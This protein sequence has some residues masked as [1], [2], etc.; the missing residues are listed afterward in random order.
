M[1]LFQ[2]KLTRAEWETI[3]KPVSD[4][5]K[6]ILNLIV[7]GYEDNNIKHNDTYT[8]LS[9]TK[10][11]KTPEIDWYIYDKYFQDD[12][13]R[14]INKYGKGTPISSISN[15]KF[16]SGR[17]LKPLKTSDS[18][19]IQNTDNV[20]RENK[21]KIF[22]F[23][24]VDLFEHMM[25]NIYK[26]NEDNIAYYLHTLIQLKKNSINN[27]NKF[28]DKYI[29][30]SIKYTRTIV[31]INDIVYNSYKLIECNKYLIKYADKELYPHQ[32][33]LF[34]LYKTQYDKTIMAEDNNKKE[35]EE[36]IKEK[37]IIERKNVRWMPKQHYLGDDEEEEARLKLEYE[38]NIKEQYELTTEQLESIENIN[39]KLD[40]LYSK[41]FIKKPTL[42]LYTAPTGTGKTLSPIGLSGQYKIIF[43]CVARHIGM[44]LAKSAISVNKKVAFAFGCE[45]S[46]DIRLHY[47]AAIDYTVNKKTGGIGKVDHSN[48][49]NVEIM[50]C[51]V[52]SY[53]TAMYYMLS[54]NNQDNIITYWDEP[55]ITL[56]YDNHD[57]HDV[58]HNNWKENK[59]PSVILSCATLP[60]NNEL[61]P[62]FSDFQ[63]KFPGAIVRNISSYDCKKSIPILDKDGYC[64][65]PHYLYNSYN[66]VSLCANNCN[67]NKSLLRYFDLR[68][69]VLFIKY[70]NEQNKNYL[71]LKDYFEDISDITMNSIK[72][73]Y[74][75]LLMEISE[76]D[77]DDI[78][79]YMIAKRKRRIGDNNDS[80]IRTYSEQTVNKQQG[81]PISRTQSVFSST[82]VAEKKINR[83]TGGLLA[84]TSDAHTLTDGPSIFL[85][86]DIDKIG[87]FYIQQ[88]KIDKSVFERIMTK[89]EYNENIIKKIDKMEA[90]ISAE[91]QKK[92]NSSDD[93]KSSKNSG[94][95]SNES[96]KLVE[97]VNTLRKKLKQISLDSMYLPNTK[98]HQEIWTP[99]GEIVN[100]AFVAD[101][102]E[103]NTS[104]I[105]QLNIE[106]NEKVLLLL[107]IGT[108]NLHN[109]NRYMEIMK[110]L[111]EEQRLYMIIASTDYIYG[112]NYQFCHGF[113]SKDLS[114]ISQQK[115]LQALGRIGRNNIQKDYTVRFRDNDMIKKLLSKPDK[116]IEATNMQKLFNSD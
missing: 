115:T 94:K 7:D 64:V 75:E 76:K 100:N 23:I 1:E 114:N 84:T 21:N 77:W 3:E 33:K 91:E 43:V 37:Q 8:F 78:Y 55:T 68:E 16:L 57:L 67:N 56:D 10:V 36:L 52:Q 86:D 47:Y 66:E 99:N 2:N 108:F 20:I 39:Q 98:P 81:K 25:K 38:K 45:T 74:L 60:T 54:F 96:K 49:N 111:A 85:T 58:I 89:I 95:L 29:D 63:R 97:D 104:E 28:V 42:V 48:G 69:I 87:N 116:N 35:I 30:E 65:L 82:S 113:I 40:D 11:D 106:N 17:D 92:D 112:T 13:N 83:N 12:I 73:Y 62:V 15:M 19:R 79:N 14:I 90:V 26:K 107:G 51:D 53:L 71:K 44:A 31:N 18:I 50:I 41:S 27:I 24:L 4:S 61:L 105:M 34:N 88:T 46:S 102:G 72:E 9:Y 70:M 80:L 101:I 6:K 5:E 109:N 32:K 103:H 93:K 22:E 59:I 110:K